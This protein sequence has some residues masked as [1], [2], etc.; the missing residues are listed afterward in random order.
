MRALELIGAIVVCFFIA[1]GVL[2]YAKA[3]DERLAK[4]KTEPKPEERKTVTRGGKRVH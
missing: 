1:W 3:W 4:S 2:A